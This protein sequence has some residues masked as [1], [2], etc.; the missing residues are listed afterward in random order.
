MTRHCDYEVG[1]DLALNHG[2]LPERNVKMFQTMRE[3]MYVLFCF[4]WTLV[5]RPFR[6]FRVGIVCA[7]LIMQ[8]KE[9]WIKSR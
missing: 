7:F 6:C 2:I 9:E 5:I 8:K 1:G 3:K 4:F